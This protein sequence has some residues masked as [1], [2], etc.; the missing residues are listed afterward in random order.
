MLLVVLGSVVSGSI[1]HVRGKKVV[2][3]FESEEMKKE[4][5]RR[6]GI[7]SLLRFK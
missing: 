5:G 3:R 1:K 6:F 4:E 2:G 7:R